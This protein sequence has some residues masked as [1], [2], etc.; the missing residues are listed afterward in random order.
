MS[1]WY[2]IVSMGRT[3]ASPGRGDELLRELFWSSSLPIAVLDAGGRLVLASKAFRDA[4]PGLIA[5]GDWERVRLEDCAGGGAFFARAVSLPPGERFALSLKM[6]FAGSEAEVTVQVTALDSRQQGRPLFLS[7]WF[8]AG[9]RATLSRSLEEVEQ[10]YR[11]LQENLPVGIYRADEE[12]NILTANGTLLRMMGFGSFEDLQE[13]SLESVWVV[14]AQRA[15]MIDQLRK[16]GAVLNHEVH[17]RRRDGEELIAAF[18][19]RGFFDSEGRLLYFDTIVQDITLRV[20]ATRELELLARTDGL[21]GLFNR[22]H[23]LGRLEAEAARTARYHRPLSLMVID[24]DRFKEV[25]DGHGHLAGDA[26]LV[27]AAARIRNALRDSDF[28]GRY[29]GEEFC[30]ALPETGLKGAM[31][32]AERLRKAMASRAHSLSGGGSLRVT[33]S[34]GVAMAGAAGVADVLARADAAL[35]AAKRAGRNRVERAADDR[36]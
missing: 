17:L 23:F 12:G 32:L 3:R 14:P 25:N 29:G 16:H 5:I 13:A 24:L 33:C 1:V 28:A 8:P 36:S 31:E 26:V 35:Y 27:S 9:G 7:E 18:D 19:A 34:I 20:Q 21:T 15:A 10:K 4:F 2:H 11:T 6:P 22:Q 30:V